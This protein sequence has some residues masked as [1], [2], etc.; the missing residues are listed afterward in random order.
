MLLYLFISFCYSIQLI[1][2]IISV[3]QVIVVLLSLLCFVC[4]AH[5]FTLITDT[6]EHLRRENFKTFVDLSPASS[7]EEVTDLIKDLTE[8]AFSQASELVNSGT[9]RVLTHIHYLASSVQTF[10]LVLLWKMKTQKSSKERRSRQL[11]WLEPLLSKYWR[12]ISVI[13][14]NIL[15]NI[16]PHTSLMIFFLFSKFVQYETGS[17]FL[18]FNLICTVKMYLNTN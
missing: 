8:V 18:S 9:L 6:M 1:P 3:L 2:C 15:Q 14:Q 13:I 17:K 16:L 4:S 5:H 11:T 10:G 7:W 12:L